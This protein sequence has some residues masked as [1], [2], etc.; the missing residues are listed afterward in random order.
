M[1]ST[2]GT[3]P[4]TDGS[5]AVIAIMVIMAIV[6]FGLTYFWWQDVATS[7]QAKKW[8]VVQGTVIS[9]RT[10]NICRGGGF[11][12][13]VHYAY[14]VEGRAYSSSQIAWNFC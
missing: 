9:S 13:V 2:T 10:M 14:E 11:Q 3:A 7:Q 1:M 8:P 5:N 4:P 6:L 12:A